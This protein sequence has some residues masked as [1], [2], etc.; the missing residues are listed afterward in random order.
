MKKADLE[1]YE[2]EGQIELFDYL[3]Q[4][5]KVYPVDIIGP[6][7]DAH[8][9]RCGSGLDEYRHIDCERCPECNARIS[10]EPWYR[11]N[12]KCFTELWGENW[13]EKIRSK[14]RE[15]RGNG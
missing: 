6:C 2:C 11:A 12:N 4:I 1:H 8:C 5:D 13:A 3:K 9:P 14:A 15:Y 10:W 7:D